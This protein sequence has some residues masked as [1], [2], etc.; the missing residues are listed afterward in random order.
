MKCDDCMHKGICKLEE[1]MNKFESEIIE[2]V[3]SVGHEFLVEVKCK[4]YW[5]SGS[6][7]NLTKR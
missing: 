3:N 4:H 5:M 2:K 6:L 7:T 1:D